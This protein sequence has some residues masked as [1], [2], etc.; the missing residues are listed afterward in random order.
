MDH[1]TLYSRP[2]PVSLLCIS[3]ENDTH[4]D[5]KVS[6]DWLLVLTGSLDSFPAACVTVTQS[7]NLS[8]NNDICWTGDGIVA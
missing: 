8:P 5:G 3:W 6:W 7:G 4:L 1:D 2:K